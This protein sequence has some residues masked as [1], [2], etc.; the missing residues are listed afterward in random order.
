[1]DAGNKGVLWADDSLIQHLEVRVHLGADE[2]GTR[3][4]AQPLKASTK[5]GE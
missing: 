4:F 2:L 1:M 3:L 5:A